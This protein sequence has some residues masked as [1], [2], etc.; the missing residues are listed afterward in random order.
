MTTISPVTVNANELVSTL[1]PDVRNHLREVA[2]FL[3]DHFG[4]RLADQAIRHGVHRLT[5]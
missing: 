1:Y 5:T 4:N 3:D 2:P